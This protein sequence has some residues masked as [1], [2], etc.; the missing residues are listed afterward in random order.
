MCVMKYT[1][2]MLKEKTL[3]RIRRQT[4]LLFA[5]LSLFPISLCRVSVHWPAQRSPW[6][7]LIPQKKGENES[8]SCRAIISYK[9]PLQ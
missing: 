4:V 2:I 3:L 9:Q 1:H 8:V 5:L 7:H 6:R